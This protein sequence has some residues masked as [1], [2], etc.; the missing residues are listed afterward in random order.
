[1]IDLGER[2]GMSEVR[3]LVAA[4]CGAERMAMRR[5]LWLAVGGEDDRAA[6]NALRVLTHLPEE[7]RG[8]L[9]EHRDAL[10]D[11]AMTTSHVGSRRLV[12]TLLERQP[13]EATDVR[14]DYLDFCL[15]RI[16]S[17]EP[18]A[19]RA[20]GLKQAYAQCRHYPELIAE[21]RQ[22]IEI[23]SLGELS[24]GLFS[25]RRQILRKLRKS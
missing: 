19:I 2:I 5:T 4:C 22:E 6:Y 10:I 23:M 1:M 20:L 9:A 24:P 18:Y 17:T 12:M 21:L 8:W 16:N 3:E 25:A 11:L 15:S 7:E 14:T 13:V